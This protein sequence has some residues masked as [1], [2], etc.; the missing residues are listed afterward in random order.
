M[1]SMYRLAGRIALLVGISVSLSGCILQRGSEAHEAA[2]WFGLREGEDFILVGG[3]GDS[4]VNIRSVG[5][6]TVVSG[7]DE[8]YLLVSEEDLDRSG[9]FIGLGIPL[10]RKF[11]G[12]GS[13]E[14]AE[15]DGRAYGSVGEGGTTDHGLTYGGLFNY[16]GG[17]STGIFLGN[18]YGLRGEILTNNT[19]S[20]THLGIGSHMPIGE[21]AV[22]DGRV[23]LFF[24]DFNQD[25]DARVDATLNGTPLGDLYQSTQVDLEDNYFGL[26]VQGQW[27]WRLPSLGGSYIRAGGFGQIAGRDGSGRFSQMTICGLCGSMSPVASVSQNFNYSESNTTFNYGARLSYGYS[28]SN[29]FGLE[30]N[31]E[32]SWLGDVTFVETPANPNQQPVRFTTDEVERDFWRLGVRLRY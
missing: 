5:F 4:Q 29:N 28:F 13:F 10:G 2:E 31:Y 12:F 22:F 15:G 6:G 9:G 7:S 24:E 17:S 14:S 19:W 16:S 1:N 8:D 11:Y 18:S 23:S 3:Y 30:L 20:A 32:K 25:H 27:T 21:N 26:N